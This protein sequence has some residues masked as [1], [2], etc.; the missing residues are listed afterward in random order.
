MEFKVWNET[1]CKWM[2]VDE[3]WMEGV[4]IKDVE[5]YNYS[6]NSDKLEV[7][8]TNGRKLTYENIHG[9]WGFP[10]EYK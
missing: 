10:V 1:K 4:N 2:T 9:T 3:E 5:E 6:S 7:V 8:Y